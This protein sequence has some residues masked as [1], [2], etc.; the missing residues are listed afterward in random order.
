MRILR[1]EEVTAFPDSREL[2]PQELAEVYSLVKA[3]FT[4]ADLQKFTEN[5]EGIPME[6]FLR[7]LEEE[8]RKSFCEVSKS[9]A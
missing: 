5:D 4:A 2:T 6:D 9:S 8:Q 3:Q 7:E 1:P